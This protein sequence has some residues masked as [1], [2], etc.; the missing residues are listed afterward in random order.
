[1]RRITVFLSDDHAVFREG[2][3]LLLEATGEI[4][5]IGEAG[6]GR[7]TVWKTKRLRPDVVLMDI[8]MPLLN[9]VEATR[10][11]KKEVPATKVLILST[12][13]D[14]QHVQQAMESGAV[15]Y[16]MKETASNDLLQAIREAGK[17]NGFFSPPIAKR[18]VRQLRNRDPRFNNTAGLALTSRQTEVL[19]LIAEGHSSQGI[20]CLL[21]VSV[22]TVEK[23]RQAL[24]DKLD[25][26]EIASLT[27]YA[28]SRGLIECRRTPNLP[29]MAEQMAGRPATN[30][31]EECG[32][33]NG[34]NS[35]TYEGSL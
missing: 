35:R 19:Q 30:G 34:I 10:K 27:R 21:V 14:D 31:D 13:S 7:E 8:A 9:G 25:I 23:H 17:G 4:D 3:R 24:M 20:A 2:L 11:I 6:N 32:L 16:L 15:G 29:A 28:M 5:V 33:T 26:H 18:L 22:K 1:M 12:Y